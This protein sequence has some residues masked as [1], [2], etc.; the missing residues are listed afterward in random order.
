MRIKITAHGYKRILER[1]GDLMDRDK[2][3]GVLSTATPLYKLSN[4]LV[5]AAKYGHRY[6]FVVLSPG[7]HGHHT[8]VTALSID[9]AFANCPEAVFAYLIRMDDLGKALWIRTKLHTLRLKHPS[10]RV[11]PL[12]PTD[13]CPVWAAFHWCDKSS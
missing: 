4:G 11:E 8:V 7:N 6:I 1:C 2:L 3:A 13:D 12:K 10:E 9:M 5:A